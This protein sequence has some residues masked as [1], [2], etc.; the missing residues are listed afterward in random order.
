MLLIHFFVLV[1]KF[2]TYFPFRTYGNLISVKNLG[3][4]GGGEE[5]FF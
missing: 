2:P 5:N 4:F 1:L 3:F